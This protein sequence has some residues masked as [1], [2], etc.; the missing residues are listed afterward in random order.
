M[1]EGHNFAEKNKGSQRQVWTCIFSDELPLWEIT[2]QV[3][4]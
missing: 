2:V 3:H 1:A 4:P